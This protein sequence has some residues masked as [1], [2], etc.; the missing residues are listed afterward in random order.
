MHHAGSLRLAACFLPAIFLSGS[1]FGQSPDPPGTAGTPGSADSPP[2]N[3]VIEFKG[4]LKGMRDNVLAVSRDGEKNAF[5]QLPDDVLGLTFVAE[6]EPGFLR[7]GMAVRFEAEFAPNGVPTAP[8]EKLEIF[9]PLQMQRLNRAARERFVPG[10]YPDDQ[11][12]AS[13]PGVASYRVVGNLMGRD[14]TG[15]LLVQA[16]ART[17]RVPL[18][19]EP[20][21]ELR[22]N[23]L[24]L[25]Q[26]GDEVSVVG[27]FQPPEDHKIKAERITITTDRVFGEQEGA[28]SRRSGRGARPG[29]PGIEPD[30]G[31]RT[32]GEST[33]A[34]QRK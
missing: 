3:E 34:R 19:A 30:A 21:I 29:R 26:P 22:F 32:T 15:V 10:V 16:G 13:R 18:A 31:S 6:A 12:P 25:A 8:V 14:P 7:R 9:Q 24:S 11:Q 17:L 5:V 2:A 28:P 1:L 23:N 4:T 20:S 27:F 33:A